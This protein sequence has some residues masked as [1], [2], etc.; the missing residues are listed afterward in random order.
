MLNPA[1]YTFFS[2]T[3]VEFGFGKIEAIG[4]V[5]VNLGAN[6]IL[7]VSDPGL[8]KV[9]VLDRVLDLLEI[10]GINCAPYTDIETNPDVYCVGRGVEAFKIFGGDGLVAVGGGSPIDVAKAIGVVAAGGF[11]IDEYGMGRRLIEKP[12][13]PLITIPTTAGTGSEVTRTAIITNRK[14]KI[15][16]AVRSPI[17]QAYLTSPRVCILDPQLTISLPERMTVATGLDTLSHGMEQL[18][19]RAS[20]P[21]SRALSMEVIRLVFNY[22]KRAALNGNDIEARLECSRPVR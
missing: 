10:T 12:I 20:H 8:R 14:E 17:G 6:R 18:V 4:Q 11:P 7:V 15:K 16:M 21:A 3:R 2:P 22:L 19:S 13:P 9:G 5:A 1:E